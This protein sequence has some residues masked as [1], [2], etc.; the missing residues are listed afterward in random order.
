M[1]SLANHQ[2]NDFVKMILMGDPGS[3]KTGAC[4]SLLDLDLKL[5][6]LDLDNGL[7]SFKAFA[8]RNHPD[9][10]AGVEYRTL[11]DKYKP[12]ALGPIVAGQPK[13]FTDSLK[14]L[15]VW[16]YDDVD[17]GHPWE[18]GSECVLIIDS[19]TLLSDAAL[20]W[21]DPLTPRGRSGDQDKRATYDIAQGALYKLLQLIT[22]ESYET[23]VIVIAHVTYIE[24]E[25]TPTKGY[26]TTVGKKLSPRVGQLFNSIALCQTTAGGKRTIQT[27]ATAMIDLKNP[28]PFEMADKYP[29]ETGLAEFFKVLR[30][31]NAERNLQ[32]KTERPKLASARR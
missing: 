10:V 30:G 15:D 24:N 23:N 28:K 6:F 7:D 1:P 8:T 20:N 5:R 18:W 13:A 26:P 32:S 12:T 14:M 19:L 3:G 29:V 2:S 25:H 22:G 21:A 11:R 31:Q 27:A 17:L 4:E 16:K 9:K